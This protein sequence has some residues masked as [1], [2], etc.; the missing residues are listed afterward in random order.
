MKI[1]ETAGGIRRPRDCSFQM[2]GCNS[3]SLA[4]SNTSICVCVCVGLMASFLLGMAASLCV[5]TL[6]CFSVDMFT[7]VNIPF[8]HHVVVATGLFRFFFF[9]FFIISFRSFFSSLRLLVSCST[10]PFDRLLSSYQVNPLELYRTIFTICF[11]SKS[12]W[13]EFQP[14][15]KCPFE[16]FFF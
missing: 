14:E 3:I 12:A 2:H 9:F 16:H 4:Q 13:V 10:R 8:F 1:V 11:R 6:D 15:V 5:L 7:E